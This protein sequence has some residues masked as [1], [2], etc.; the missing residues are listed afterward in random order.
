MFPNG[1]G[2]NERFWRENQTRCNGRSGGC[3]RNELKPYI[4]CQ[5]ITGTNDDFVNW[6]LRN[7]K[8]VIEIETFSLTKLPS[9]KVPTILSQPLCA[10]EVIIFGTSALGLR[11][12][13]TNPSGSHDHQLCIYSWPTFMETRTTQENC[14]INICITRTLIARFIGQTWD[15]SR[16][17]RTQ[18]GPM[19]A[20]WTLLSGE[21]FHVFEM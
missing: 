15:P 21:C 5:A 9:V 2:L 17:D 11:L 7:K 10:Y 8:N 13:C 6:T 18:V 3:D 19:L 4:A 20:P 16:A 14:V 12:S 1:W